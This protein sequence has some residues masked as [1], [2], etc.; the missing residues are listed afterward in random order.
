MIASKRDIILIF[1]NHQLIQ[2]ILKAGGDKKLAKCYRPIYLQHLMNKI[3]EKT[4]YTRI[5]SFFHFYELISK[6]QFGFLKNKSTAQ[7]TI[8]VLDYSLPALKNENFTL[9]VTL[10]LSKAFDCVD[11]DNLLTK[12]EKYG[13]RGNVL[14]L[15]KSY[16]SNRRQK[17]RIGNH[18]STEGCMSMDL[19]VPQGSCLGP[20][21]YLIYANDIND[22]VTG[23][24]IITFADDIVLIANG[25]NLEEMINLINSNLSIIY[26]WCVYNYLT[27]N[28]TKSQCIIFSNR[29]IQISVEIEINGEKINIVSVVKY[30]GIYLDSKLNLS[31]QLTQV[32]DK[33]SQI[34]GVTWK[35]TRKF[36][37]STAKI[38]YFAFAYSHIS[39]GISA[40]G[41]IFL[42]HNCSRTHS[43][44][45][46]IVMNLFSWHFPKD[47]YKS[48]C[49][50]LWILSVIDI[51]KLNLAVLLYNMKN[52]NF[53]SGIEFE[54]YEKCY[55]MRND[56][57]LK[58][59]FP[60]TNVLK[61]HFNY[62][63]PLTWNT[64]PLEIRHQNTES[65]F[66]NSY[67]AYLLSEFKKA[68]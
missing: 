18:F 63:M 23:V 17:V 11:H 45:K 22:I 20:L 6:N 49:E 26:E 61:M 38:F 25:D 50:K 32:N 60:R 44:H 56:N 35:L 5:Y 21:F 54:P 2:P 31:H 33:L 10:D 8:K 36:N 3:F 27:I 39:Y 52:N 28:P 58:V 7:A 47:D 59:P 68:I 12:F 41:G 19:G 24:K 30:L 15:I 46:R 66:K 57:E 48:I 64:I 29:R 14:K 34:C 43:L 9:A 65:K 1:S 42:T 4:L 51:Y 16:L 40:W 55:H 37:V 62:T 67:K 13:V 53:L